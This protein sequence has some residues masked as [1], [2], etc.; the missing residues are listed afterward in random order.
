MASAAFFIRLSSTC[1]TQDGVAAHLGQ[2]LGHVMLDLHMA[3]PHLDAGQFDRV[4]DDVLRAG[5][6]A[7]RLALLHEGAYAV[8]DL[9]GTLGL[10]G[11]FVERGHQ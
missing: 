8:D 2:A 7:L 11:G 1:S 5:R 9:A 3:A 6:H 10:A 4:A